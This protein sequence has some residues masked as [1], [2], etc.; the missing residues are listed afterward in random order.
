MSDDSPTPTNESR[1]YPPLTPTRRFWVELPQPASWRNGHVNKNQKA[2]PAET[3]IT[4]SDESEDEVEDDPVGDLDK[5]ELQ[6]IVAEFTWPNGRKYYYARTRDEVVRKFTPN[7][8]RQYFP[9]LL[10]EYEEDKAAGHLEK[11]FD[12]RS[13][14]VL[15][16]D[17]PP[18]PSNHKATR[19][20][21]R[22]DYSWDIPSGSDEDEEDELES[23]DMT[24]PVRITRSARNPPVL[25]P[26]KS[27]RRNPP[28]S[29]SRALSDPIS[30]SDDASEEAAPVPRQ[31]ARKGPRAAAEY[32]IVTPFSVYA[33]ESDGADG[34]LYTHMP[35]CVKC[36]TAPTHMQ[37]PKGRGRKRKLDEF[38]MGEEEIISSKG[39]WV[40]CKFC[41]QAV[42]FGCLAKATRDQMI[43]D[44]RKLEEKSQ[45]R[46]SDSDDFDSPPPKRKDLSA[47]ETT[48]YICSSCSDMSPCLGCSEMLPQ[49]H[50]TNPSLPSPDPVPQSD[51]VGPP[52]VKHVAQSQP[53]PPP[54]LLFR[55][56]TCRRAAHY[57]HLPPLQADEDTKLSPARIAAEYHDFGWQCKDCHSWVY[58][59]DCILAWRPYPAKAQEPK[60]APGEFPQVKG[61]LPR[62]YLVK[63]EARSFKRVEW[64]PHRFLAARAEPKLNN[65]LRGKGTKSRPQLLEYSSSEVQERLAARAKATGATYE[66]IHN[67]IPRLLDD[68]LQ[69][70][71]TPSSDPDAELRIPAAWKTVDR[72]LDVLF[73]KRRSKS[74]PKREPMKKKT[75]QIVT[76]DEESGQEDENDDEKVEIID[77][78]KL[79][80]LLTETWAQ[81]KRRN[82]EITSRDCKDVV[83]AFIK[84]LDLPHESATW[85]T[86][87]TDEE[88]A[89]SFRAAFDNLV[90]ARSV[91]VPVL[92]RELERRRDDR[93][94]KQFGPMVQPDWQPEPLKLKPFQLDGLRWLFNC[95][96]NHQHC[97][98][99]DEMGLGKTVQIAT[100]IGTLVRE[101]KIFPILIVVPNSTITNWVREMELWA[102]GVRVVMFAGSAKSREI[103]AQY[104]LVNPS[105]QSSKLAYHVLLATYDSITNPRDFGPIF[106][107]VPRWE[108]TIVDEGQRLKSD[109]SLI[110]KRM[111]ELNSKHRILMTG[112]PINNNIRE[113]FNLLNYLDPDVWNDLPAYEAKFDPDNLTEELVKELHG[114]LR[115]Y[116]L[117]RVKADVMKDLPR[118]HEV[119]VPVNMTTLQL[120]VWK[121]ILNNSPQLLANLAQNA[122]QVQG[123]TTVKLSGKVNMNNAL[124]QIRKSLQHPYLVSLE[125]EQPTDSRAE[126]HKQLVEASTK[127]RF[128]Q[129]MLPKLKARGHRVL[130]FSQFTIALNIIEDFL[131][132][133]GYK[134]LRLDGDTP[135]RQR[136]KDMDAFNKPGADYFIYILS[137]KA[138]GVG[139]NLW[140]ADVVI[141]HDVDFNPH[142]DLQAIARAHRMGQK[143]PV[144]VFTLMVKD[145]AEEKMVE[146]GK[147]K[148]ILDHVIVKKMDDED[149]QDNS[150]Q[151][152]LS[153]G[154]KALF[155]PNAKINTTCK[156]SYMLSHTNANLALDSS[157]E[158]DDLI[159]RV[160]AEAEKPLDEESSTGL[161]FGFTN[162]WEPQAGSDVVLTEYKAGAGE[163]AE[164][165]ADF[166]AKVLDQSKKQEEEAATA[167]R[168]QSG[169]GVRRKA[170]KADYVETAPD[171]PS[172]K[173]AANKLDDDS[174]YAVDGDGSD[175]DGASNPD[176]EPVQEDIATLQNLLP[177]VQSQ[178]LP[179]TS[180]KPKKRRRKNMA[181]M[182]DSYQDN[183][184]RTS[185][186]SLRDDSTPCGVCS[187]HHPFVTCQDD[188]DG[189]IVQQMRQAIT[190]PN[191]PEPVAYKIAALKAL[192]EYVVR[193]S[194]K[195]ANSNSAMFIAQSGQ[196]APAP[197]PYV[198]AQT[199][200]PVV[201]NQAVRGVSS[202]AGNQTLRAPAQV[203]NSHP[204]GSVH[205]WRLSNGLSNGHHST[206]NPTNSG[207]IRPP[208]LP[209]GRRAP[210]PFPLDPAPSS[211][212]RPNPPAP[213]SSAP[214]SQPTPSRPRTCKLC[215]QALHS[216]S[217]CPMVSTSNIPH[218][219][220]RLVSEQAQLAASS[221]GVQSVE[222]KLFVDELSRV[223]AKLVQQGAALKD[224]SAP[225][226]VDSD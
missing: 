79:D 141:L 138:G 53:P 98:L 139:I 161:N 16:K 135:S 173:K 54:P 91:F 58:P 214:V 6:E 104:E 51:P 47:L 153:Y 43:R 204:N 123:G 181:T 145:S 121:S 42:H 151:S 190:D 157:E 80:N 206:P 116:F 95:W 120:E 146:I 129:M 55:C 103:I 48:S 140:S 85:D 122:A 66:P 56:V 24:P 9:E 30:V 100:F 211:S 219:R 165:D 225:I 20:P 25:S 203:P 52:S 127:L 105:T 8:M 183:A 50:S 137:T 208:S 110:F 209:Q 93:K 33:T 17:R 218:L 32:A 13:S 154:A 184:S 182:N 176:L 207:Q 18:L 14:V 83:W 15:P 89:R 31:K 213:S 35:N 3:L 88:G 29:Y 115:P 92:T 27:R 11:D 108:V 36:G 118:K 170:T 63:W 187:K 175:A 215:R 223:L 150:L 78:V 160:R 69:L 185:L 67:T 221:R 60:L 49:S 106:K 41:C 62:E 136:Q 45:L 134:Y 101:K 193:A 158:L 114:I 84:W 149:V 198:P 86:P 74:A 113:M 71:I 216:L 174:D 94:P 12:P 128:L 200:H 119:I 40:A 76:S 109:G 188:I 4:I 205:T 133:E 199:N 125:L 1:L 168:E 26:R 172:R 179:E 117:R 57:Q 144:L 222:D 7:L 61:F 10:D 111:K 142:N 220:Q 124:M 59:V 212:P 156:S 64:V 97:I 39:G 194:L 65:F 197:V 126:A 107:R 75:N 201:P 186:L 90:L 224:G 143:K 37:K 217:R 155:E 167:A 38:E 23:D 68:D 164:A 163:D 112:T 195:R 202:A 82:G 169:R 189:N 44:I 210:A 87:P 162:I 152:M 70:E 28:V 21:T 102:P 226:V 191:N 19:R 132:G 96:W 147:K 81:R 5:L 178:F 180:G 148:L 77:G 177:P 46:D 192:D 131:M 99:A 130:L 34:P 159:D 22:A 171:A 73:L 72:I 2:S 196:R 166:W